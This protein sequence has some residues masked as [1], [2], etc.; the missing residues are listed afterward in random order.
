MGTPPCSS[1]KNLTMLRNSLSYLSLLLISVAFFTSCSKDE[2][3]QEIEY[4]RLDPIFKT[5]QEIRAEITVEPARDLKKPGKIYFYNGYVFVNERFEGIHI[6][7]NFDPANPVPIAFLNIPGN[8][9]MAVQGDFLYA[10]NAIDLLTLDISDPANPV[11]VNRDEGVFPPQFFFDEGNDTYLIGYDEIPVKEVVDC[12]FADLVRNQGGFGWG[13]MPEAMTFDASF[14]STAGS[15]APGGGVGG[16]M[17]RFTLANNRLYTVDFSTLRVFNLQNP[18]MP[19]LVSEVQVGWNIETIFPYE[20]NLFL[21]SSNGMFIYDASQPD[22]PQFMSEFS[23]ANACDP[24]FVKDNY[25]YV[26]LRSGNMCA[27]FTDQLDLI[28]ITDLRNPFLEKTFPMDNPHGLSIS[29]NTLFLCEG[30]N[31]LKSFDIEVPQDLDKN[32]LDQIVDRDAYDVIVVPNQDNVL[33]MIGRD[34]LYQYN[35]DNPGNLQLLSQIPVNP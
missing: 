13:P 20:T 4:I 23:H 17:A 30:A 29:G 26:T 27:G 10:D 1:K 5:T 19:N 15:A 21:G 3:M 6:I 34:G 16:S 24:V 25:A 8:I 33:L 22:Q 11:L 2:C 9:D 18:A 32:L 31:G 7:N 12:D 28:D 14:N 35:F